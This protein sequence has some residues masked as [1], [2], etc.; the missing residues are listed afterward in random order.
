MKNKRDVVFSENG[1]IIGVI[2]N[3]IFHKRVNSK[4]HFL[5]KP[6]A[7]SF[8]EIAINEILLKKVKKIMVHAIDTKK[9]YVTDVTDFTKKSFPIN[10]GYGNQL[11]LTLSEWSV[12]EP[13]KNTYR[14]Y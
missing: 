3:D 13:K 11:A 6:P 9:R 1:K 2:I 12:L 10:R 5:R 7:I 8:D 14:E 4:S